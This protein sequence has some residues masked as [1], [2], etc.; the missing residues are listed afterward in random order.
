MKNSKNIYEALNEIDFD[1]EDYEK[2]TLSDIE[3][4][5]L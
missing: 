4:K 5:K 1:F 3:K 2:E